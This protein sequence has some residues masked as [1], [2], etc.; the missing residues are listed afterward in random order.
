MRAGMK[1]GEMSGRTQAWGG[2][3]HKISRERREQIR[4]EVEAE[5][6]EMTLRELREFAGKT[7]ED[8]ANLVSISQGQVSETERREDHR[9]ST[10]RRYVEAL[11]GELGLVASFGNKQIK[12]QL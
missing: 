10:L 1:G 5:I 4:T 12:L 8:V 2:I 6:L 11:G 7:Q 9:V 3:K